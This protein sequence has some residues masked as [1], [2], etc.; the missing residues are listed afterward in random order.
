MS[1]ERALPPAR[2]PLLPRSRG[3]RWALAALL[4]FALLRGLAFAVMIPAFWAPDEDYH[5]LYGEH[6]AAQHSL[7]DPDKPIYPREYQ[8]LAEVIKYDSY[9]SGPR[10]DFS[11]DPRKSLRALEALPDSAREPTL[12]GR[13]VGVVHPP[14]YHLTVAAVDRAA[15]EASMLTRLTWARIMT[16]LF[17]V[18]AVYAAWLLAAQVFTRFRLQILAAFLVAV[19]PI[20][21]YEAGIVNHDSALIAFFT[22]GMAMMLFVVR[23]PPRPRQGAWLAAPI[24]LALLVKGTALVLLPLAALALLAQGLTWRPAWRQTARS[25]LLAL[26]LIALLAGWWYVR[27]QLVYGSATGAVSD[28]VGA[29]KHPSLG[30]YLGFVRSWTLLT[31]RTYWFHFVFFETPGP[32]LEYFVPMAIGAIGIAGLAV[33]AWSERRRLLDP[34]RARLRQIVL[35]V[36]AALL[37]YLSF[38]WLDVARMAA[39]QPFLVNGGRYLVPAYAGVAVLLIIGLRRLFRGRLESYALVGAALVATAFCARVFY[40]YYIQRYFGE[41]EVGELLRRIS[42]DRP[43]FVTPFTLGLLGALVIVSLAAFAVAVLRA[44]PDTVSTPPSPPAS[45]NA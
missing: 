34:A 23:T 4:A 24:V 3:A 18:L 37:L 32:S 2:P 44:P 10:S 40:R 25:A 35:M 8:K 28:V 19:Q 15:G 41:G 26:G 36:L 43:E 14:L 21:A 9:D 22:A 31:Y 7:I 17:G 6:L 5:F 1:A 27:A 16:T 12:E 20:V 38:L 11:G 13:G 45:S 42:F 39:G 33:A 29:S 30:D